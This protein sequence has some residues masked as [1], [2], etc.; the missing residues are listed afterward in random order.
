MS[1]T[2]LHPSRA[3]PSRGGGPMGGGYA[4]VFAPGRTLP[5]L[6]R[7]GL[8]MAMVAAA[9][10]FALALEPLV[11][12]ANLSLVFVL[13][14]VF[15]AAGFGWGPS[16]A[17]AVAGV[18]AMDFFFVTPRYTLLVDSPQDLWALGLLLVVGAAVSAVAAHASQRAVEARVAA[19]RAEALQAFANV[20]MRSPPV[21]EV[22]RAAAETLARL[23]DAPALVLVERGEAL[24]PAAAERGAKLSEADAEAARLAL[25][26]GVAMRAMTYPTIQAAFD[27]WPTPGEPGRRSVLGVRLAGRER[28]R[29]ADPAVLVEPVAAYLAAALA[30][31]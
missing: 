19:R 18:L 11:G 23:F 17:A 5:Q 8:A 4:S 28:A 2:S 22:E 27:F 24:V 1:E 10:M 25:S 15:A 6:A 30:R 12:A 20:V 7:Y 3:R 14:V 13:P 26:S 16:L 29:F 21:A 31:D 9:T